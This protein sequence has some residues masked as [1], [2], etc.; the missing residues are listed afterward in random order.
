MRCSVP[1]RAAPDSTQTS[2]MLRSLCIFGL[3]LL[4]TALDSSCRRHQ[5]AAPLPPPPPAPAASGTPEPSTSPAPATAQPPPTSPA[6]RPQH[7]A[8]E[9]SPNATPAAPSAPPTATRPQIGLILTADQQRQYNRAVDDSLARARASLASVSGRQL[10]PAQQ[11]NLGQ[12]QNFI[13]QAET[14]RASDLPAAK[15][16]AERAEVLAK[17][18]AKSVR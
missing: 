2:Y 8:N 12:I 10:T 1:P 7:P 9:P 16:L 18:L 13:Q 3:A 15:R 14:A 17:N 4:L 5:G 6:H 11:T